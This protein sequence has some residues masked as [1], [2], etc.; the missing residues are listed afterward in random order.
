[1]H[2]D[3]AGQRGRSPG[4]NQKSKCQKSTYLRELDMEGSLQLTRGSAKVT[5]K[6]YLAQGH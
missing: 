2:R 3:G 5:L 1:M 6:Q 4:E